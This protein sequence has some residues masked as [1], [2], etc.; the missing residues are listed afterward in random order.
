MKIVAQC[1]I[2]EIRLSVK[3]LKPI[4]DAARIKPVNDKL[5]RCR[6]QDNNPDSQS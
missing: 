6:N 1:F 5:E 4:A 2:L 3:N